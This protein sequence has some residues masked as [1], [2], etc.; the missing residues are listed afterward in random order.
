MIMF[1]SY[2][3]PYASDGP[4]WSEVVK[5]AEYCRSN[6]LVGL[7]AVNNIFKPDQLVRVGLLPRIRQ[8]Q[9]RNMI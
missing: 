2:V 9:P 6:W 7:L 5:E 1:I 3:L 8:I 4:L